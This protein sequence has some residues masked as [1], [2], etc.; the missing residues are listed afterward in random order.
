MVSRQLS[1][2]QVLMDLMVGR[3]KTRAKGP[4]LNDKDQNKGPDQTNKD[5]KCCWL[6]FMDCFGESSLLLPIYFFCVCCL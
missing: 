4:E 5:W 3:K 1:E 6:D 2:Q